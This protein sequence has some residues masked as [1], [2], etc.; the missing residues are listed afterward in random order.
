MAKLATTRPAAAAPDIGA[1]LAA[2]AW[3]AIRASA[4]PAAIVLLALILRTVR[5]ELQAWTPDTY[6]QMNAAH[7]LVAGQI[8]VSGFYP[9]GVAIV[10]APAFVFFPQTLATQQSVIIA[11]SL[12]LIVVAYIAARHATPDRIAPV[13][14]A[15]GV[16]TAPQFVYFSRDGLYDA[17]NAA[18]IVTAILVVPWLRG[19]SLPTF[20]AYGV[21]LAIAISIRASN[22]AFLPAIVIYWAGIAGA[23][24]NPAAIWRSTFRR[25]P[26]VAGIAMVISFAFFAFIGGAAGHL[27]GSP[28]TLQ[29]AAAHIVYYAGSEFGGPLGAILLVPLA[30]LGSTYLWSRNRP[31]LCAS[32]YM[33]AIFPLVH[34]PL[35]F[36]SSRY[37]LPSLVFALLL[38]AYA[39]AAVVA[40][41]A[42]QPV[43]TRHAWR[44]LA[45]GPVLLLGVYFIAYDTVTL[46][47]W[48]D[49]AARSDEAAYRQL[50][51]VVAAL[52][53][54]SLLIS[55]GVRGVRDGDAHVEYLDLIDFSLSTGNTPQRVDEIMQR[56]D[57]S[58]AQGRSVYYLYTRVEGV[59]GTFAASGP[60]YQAYFDAVSQ[61][62]HV[63]E[64]FASNVKHFRLY[65]IDPPSRAEPHSGAA[66]P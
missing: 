64:V 56:V 48:P 26:V 47:H 52:P 32:I 3:P 1:W 41:T 13:L 9:P 31:L 27:R 7:R 20:V 37:M 23:G 49:S 63:D 65:K 10:L 39:P 14:L 33:L 35:P 44:A 22:P 50:R 11:W 53:A 46:A 54:G 8:P 61:R 24:L 58:L 5:L 59:T 40:V 15:F 6:E 25:G 66:L 18:W 2:H 21:L 30:E 4:V 28:I 17:I 36:E 34:V 19:R 45:A 12:V 16:A 29:Y 38:A 55:T 57:A 42:R 43:R 60:G 62:F 51:P